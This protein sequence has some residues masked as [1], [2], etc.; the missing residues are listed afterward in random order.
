MNN[1]N[2]SGTF[3]CKHQADAEHSITIRLCN[4]SK[5][6]KYQ[7]RFAMEHDYDMVGLLHW[8]IQLEIQGNKHALVE[9]IREALQWQ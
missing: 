8:G 2:N 9:V 3:I 5:L 6:M 1:V 4:Q 7:Q